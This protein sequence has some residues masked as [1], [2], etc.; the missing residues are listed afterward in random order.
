VG[1]IL[2]HDKP[3]HTLIH[4]LLRTT[5][6]VASH[7][8]IG[9]Q[10]SLFYLLTYGLKF[11]IGIPPAQELYAPPSHSKYHPQYLVLGTIIITQIFQPPI[12]SSL[13]LGFNCSLQPIPSP[14][15]STPSTYV[16]HLM[17]NNTKFNCPISHAHK[18][19]VTAFRFFTVA[20]KYL[21]CH[22][23]CTGAHS[24]VVG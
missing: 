7:Q 20:S 22:I 16:L 19:W 8:G 12:I 11:S 9:L 13:P 5:L 1:P 15:V 2:S 4:F 21:N 3:V 6:K 23:F 17:Y 24:S 10:G 18:L 14:K